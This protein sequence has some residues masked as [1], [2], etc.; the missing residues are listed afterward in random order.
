[1]STAFPT[2]PDQSVAAV[3]LVAL[4]DS[5]YARVG[6]WDAFSSGGNWGFSGNDSVFVVGELEYSYALSNDALPGKL[7]VAA[8]YESA[9][10][11]SGEPISAVHEYSFQFEQSL[12]RERLLDEEDFQGLALFAG[13]YPRFPGPQ[14]TEE[15]IGDSLVAGLAYIGLIPGRDDD[16]VGAGV[17]CAKLFQGGTGQETVFE[18][19]YK[20]SITP[21]V[22]IQPDMQYVASP[23]G[24]YPDALVVG[25][26]FELTW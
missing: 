5:W 12:Y 9:G 16:V 22:S 8:T 14:V 24:I 10:T 3:V 26:R 11:L 6:V 18:L 7:T 13:Y 15:S 25:L 4:T 2:Y 20:A 1:M 23:S 21:R 19:F 17:A